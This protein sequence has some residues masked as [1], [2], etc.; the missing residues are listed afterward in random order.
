MAPIRIGTGKG[1]GEGEGRSCHREKPVSP[2]KNPG[3]GAER[4]VVTVFSK[5][6]KS[7]FL[8]LVTHRGSSVE[9]RGGR[10]AGCSG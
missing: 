6:P 10:Q 4:V 9:G 7:P 3:D 8:G 5:W 1:N 2:L